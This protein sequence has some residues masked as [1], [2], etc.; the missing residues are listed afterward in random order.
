M[1]WIIVLDKKH[2][3]GTLGIIGVGLIGGSLSLALKAH[4]AVDRVIGFG[5]N[6]ERLKSAKNTGIIDQYSLGFELL[7][8][9]DIVV[10]CTPV[11]SMAAAFSAVEQFASKYTVITDVGSTKQYVVDIAK[12][13]LSSKYSQFVAG[14]P[15]AGTEKSGF[16]A[17]YSTLY[18]D[19]R[20]IL[21]P[22][23][24]TNADATQQIESM[25]KNAGADV[26]CMPISTHDEVLAATSHL[27]HLLAYSLVDSLAKLSSHDD[28]FRFA[29]GGFR[30]FTRI[31]SSDVQMWRDISFTNKQ[32][33]ISVLDTFT[34]DMAL[35]R[36]ALVADDETYVTN[37]FDNAKAARAE[38]LKRFEPNTNY[39]KC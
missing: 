31:A 15:I 38:Y 27:P 3:I 23:S 21:T 6:E 36:D 8:Q 14:H 26:V 30:D 24:A 22:D 39:K 32:A 7:E 20:V 4:S 17:A 33:L 35:L 1:H 16:E 2:R 37:V 34:K 28:I 13:Q 25:W 18:A 11:R 5:R 9:C 10:V 19:R 12:E 29:A